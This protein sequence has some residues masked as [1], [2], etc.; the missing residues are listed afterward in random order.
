MLGKYPEDGLKLFEKDLP[1]FK[2]E[3][4]KLMNQPIDF[5]LL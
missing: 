1:D 5:Y 3:D 4:L 2:P